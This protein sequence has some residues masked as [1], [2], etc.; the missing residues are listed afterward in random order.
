MKTLPRVLRFDLERAVEEIVEF[1]RGQLGEKGAVIGLSGGVDSSVTAALLVRA[2]SA[3]RVYALIMPTSFTPREDVEDARML[4]KTLGIRFKE[5]G[6]DGI[7]DAYAASLDASPDSE[8][9]KMP[10]ANLRARVR[11]SLLYF[12]ANKLGY[13]VAGTG[14]KSEMLIG[15]FT[16]YGDGGVD[17]LPIAHLYKS[18]VRALA[19]HLGLPERIARKPAAPRLYPGHRAV[20]ELP[21]DYD[22]LDLLLYYIFDEGL[23]LE[24]AAERS[25]LSLRVAQWVCRSFH[26]SEHKRRMPPSLLVIKHRPPEGKPLSPPSPS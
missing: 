19:L 5:I 23:E 15:Y 6:I 12:H 24:E 9:Y 20:E 7:V 22:Q 18:Q 8:E 17:F 21:A 4:A 13:L 11:M 26:A 16:K 2:I 10:F 3:E 25:G 14:D 1:I